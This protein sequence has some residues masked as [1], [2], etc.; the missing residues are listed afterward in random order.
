MFKLIQT[1]R[2]LPEHL[3]EIIDPVIQR[4]AFFAHPENLLLAMAMDERKHIRELAFRRL[5]KSRNQPSLCKN[6]RNFLPPDLNFQATDYTELIN[7]STCKL[8]SPPMIVHVTTESML[9]F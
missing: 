5:L 7:W 8:S 2:Y 1:S 9:F 3:L 4:N 6:V